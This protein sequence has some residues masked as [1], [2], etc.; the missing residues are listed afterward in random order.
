M[1]LTIGMP[2][3]LS[4]L[5]AKLDDLPDERKPSNNK[6]YSVYNCLSEAGALSPYRCF[7]G[8]FLLV[9]DGTEIVVLLISPKITFANRVFSLA[10]K[11]PTLIFYN[12]SQEPGAY[13][14]TLRFSK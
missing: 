10:N 13:L 2:E 5:T 7:Q 1:A 12:N 11:A 8:E 4:M 3:L 14:T 6:K 9:G